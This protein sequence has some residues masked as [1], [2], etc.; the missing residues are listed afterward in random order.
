MN[1]GQDNSGPRG[2]CLLSRSIYCPCPE[3]RVPLKPLFWMNWPSF[4]LFIT[5]SR[6][7][8]PSSSI[9]LILCFAFLPAGKW[10]EGRGWEELWQGICLS[11]FC[12]GKWAAIAHYKRGWMMHRKK[13]KKSSLV[14][15]LGIPNKFLFPFCK[16]IKVIQTLLSEKWKFIC[17]LE[18]SFQAMGSLVSQLLIVDFFPIEF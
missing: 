12:S 1:R 4:H 9:Y 2:I 13:K 3:K 15:V 6:L 5:H 10:K 17:K 8:F 16:E 11:G 14:W 18:F 7:K